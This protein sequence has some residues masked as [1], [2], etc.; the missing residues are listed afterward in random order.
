MPTLLPE[1]YDE[2]SRHDWTYMMSDDS[3]IY[4][5][6]QKIRDHLEVVSRQSPEHL[7]LFN[8]YKNYAWGKGPK[9]ERPNA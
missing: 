3:T 8:A 6:G 2:L 1:Y 7:K 9:P 4:R 5:R